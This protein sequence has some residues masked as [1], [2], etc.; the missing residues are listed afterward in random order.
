MAHEFP[1]KQWL[2]D[3]TLIVIFGFLRSG[4]VDRMALVNAH[5]YRLARKRRIT[6]RISKK[7]LNTGSVQRATELLECHGTSVQQ[8]SR[9]TQAVRSRSR[10][11]V[12]IFRICIRLSLSL[13][14][15]ALVGEYRESD[16]LRSVWVPRGC[17]FS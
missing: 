4:D 5:W 12:N 11:T 14:L 9:D 6:L 15:L 8:L 10:I 13:S 17:T 3:D 2:F 1:H 16:R 7:V